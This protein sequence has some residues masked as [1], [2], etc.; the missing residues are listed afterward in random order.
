MM[1]TGRSDSNGRPKVCG[2][3]GGTTS[4]RCHAVTVVTAIPKAMKG[5]G[6]L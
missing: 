4:I 2:T 6:G 5:G 1:F 3:L